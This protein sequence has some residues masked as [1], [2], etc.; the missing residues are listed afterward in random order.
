M[1]RLTIG[2]AALLLAVPLSNG[3]A[4]TQDAVPTKKP[5]AQMVAP[6]D[7]QK[8]KR[9]TVID[10]KWM[11]MKPGTR[12][13]YE[14][15]STEDDG[16]VVPH[17]ITVTVT[18][19]RKVVAGV[20]TL[21]SYDLDYSD[22]ELVEAELAFYAQDND[23]NVWQF[24]EYPEEYEDGKFIKAPT[25]LHGFK[26]ARAG[27][28]MPADPQ[29]GDKEFAEG[30]GPAVGWK[31][32]GIVYQVD[33]RVIVPAGTFEGVLVIKEQ[34]AGEKDAEQ[35][36]YYAPYIGNVRTGWLGKD[37]KTTESMQL[38]KIEYLDHMAL[39]DVRRQAIKLEADAYRRS[40]EVYAKTAPSVIIYDVKPVAK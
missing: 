33:E 14:G 31:D 26:K 1:I 27:V 39:R 19:L 16:K 9:S 11:P 34:A 17:R 3:R 28:T 13:T 36:K 10:N 8:F 5:S 40:K 24:G 21:V 22:G 38:T 7:P 29:T 20:Q 18:N 4:L 30:W 25:W 15:T 12:W 23:G 37:A 32:R 35:L 6:V 2:M